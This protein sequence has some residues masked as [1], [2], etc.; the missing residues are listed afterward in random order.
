MAKISK[1]DFKFKLAGYGHYK[2]AY[3]SQSQGRVGL[4]LST[5]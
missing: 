2:V 5:I 3:T 4:A 1:Y